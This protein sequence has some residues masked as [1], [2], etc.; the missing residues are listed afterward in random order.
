MSQLVETAAKTPF[1]LK[2]VADGARQL[3]AYGFAAERR[4]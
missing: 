3:L 2:G 1:D 4:E